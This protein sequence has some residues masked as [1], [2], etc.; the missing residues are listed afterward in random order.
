MSIDVTRTLLTILTSHIQWSCLWQQGTQYLKTLKI[1]RI[2]DQFHC[3]VDL[4][5]NTGMKGFMVTIQSNNKD[6]VNTFTCSPGSA[7]CLLLEATVKILQQTTQKADRY[8][9]MS[10]IGNFLQRSADSELN[11]VLKTNSGSTLISLHRENTILLDSS[12]KLT[13]S[14]NPE[15]WKNQNN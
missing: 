6:R 13:S 12:R 3:L 15:Y 9:W 10:L 8:F 4:T 11:L 5:F 14:Q 2:D 7:H 1:L